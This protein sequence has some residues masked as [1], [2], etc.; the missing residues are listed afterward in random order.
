MLRRIGLSNVKRIPFLVWQTINKD[1]RY[2]ILEDFTGKN[3][4]GIL[5]EYKG[6]SILNLVDSHNLNNGELPEVDILMGSFSGGSSG[7][8]FAG[9]IIIKIK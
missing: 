3:D 6:Y 8:Q 9:K 1:C 5:I 4:S 2:M 7:H